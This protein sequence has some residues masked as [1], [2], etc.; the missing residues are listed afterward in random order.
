MHVARYDN[1]RCKQI[2]L[3]EDDVNSDLVDLKSEP[4]KAFIFV[5]DIRMTL[6]LDYKSILQFII[7]LF[8]CIKC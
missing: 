5:N 7:S 3:I 8:Q 6:L 4:K 2:G 1:N